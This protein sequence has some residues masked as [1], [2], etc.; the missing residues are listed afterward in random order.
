MICTI[1]GNR[2]ELMWVNDKELGDVWGLILKVLRST[3]DSIFL[4][5]GIWNL[6]V[7]KELVQTRLYIYGPVGGGMVGKIFHKIWTHI[8]NVQ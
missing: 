6:T 3:V 4:Y 5:P 7:R 1:S 2:S 8:F